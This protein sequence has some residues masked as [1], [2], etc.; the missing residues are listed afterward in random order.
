MNSLF[1]EI[2]I[3]TL[4]DSDFNLDSDDKIT[5]KDKRVSVVLFHDTELESQHIVQFFK[6]VAKRVAGLVFYACDMT[7]QT[8]IS[9]A[10]T[11]LSDDSSSP[12]QKFVVHGL[13]SLIVY[14]N[15]KP[16]TIYNG[17]IDEHSI[18]LFCGSIVN[19]KI[20]KEDDEIN[21]PK[22]IEK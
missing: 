5:L 10:F 17:L 13:P 8:G 16:Q 9:Q 6:N 2:K 18:L 15:G 1:P 14:K 7:I 3:K 20:E 4:S 21:I 11:Q 12:Y 22:S 19:L